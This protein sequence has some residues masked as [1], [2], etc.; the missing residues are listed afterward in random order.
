ML[1][2]LLERSLQKIQINR[3]LVKNREEEIDSNKRTK[4]ANRNNWIYKQWSKLHIP[5][6]DQPIA[7][8]RK[9]KKLGENPT[10]QE[11]LSS[12]RRVKRC[13]E[14]SLELANA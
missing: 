2:S 9:W 13:A 10:P 8:S 1:S 7:P 6:W 3:I 4:R 5:W 14:R 11:V 12:W